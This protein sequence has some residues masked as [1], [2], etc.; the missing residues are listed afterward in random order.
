MRKKRAEY[1]FNGRPCKY[2]HVGPRYKNGNCVTCLLER[3]SEKQKDEQFAE[4]KRQREK[5][6]HWS[7]V[8]I[9]RKPL[10]V[11]RADN[12]EA[13]KEYARTS[14]TKHPERRRS[15]SPGYRRQNMNTAKKR[16]RNDN[17]QTHAATK[18]TTTKKTHQNN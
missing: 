4:S 15:E 1:V 13:S 3:E 12:T 11:R 16:N 18:G 8:E 17:K 14:Y 9:S 5:D 7:D 2:G 10:R 6:R